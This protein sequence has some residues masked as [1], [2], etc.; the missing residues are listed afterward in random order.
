MAGVGD[1][2]VQRG[3]NL[4]CSC[5][6]REGVGSVILGRWVE[7]EGWPGRDLTKGRSRCGQTRRSLT[8]GGVRRERPG[9]KD[10]KLSWAAP[11]VQ[12]E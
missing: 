11:V 2:E 6:E 4:V 7:V 12:C 10:N 5:R 8:G 9:E 3:R 1:R